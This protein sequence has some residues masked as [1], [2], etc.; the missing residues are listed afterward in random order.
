M[1]KTQIGTAKVENG[2]GTTEYTVPADAHIGENT[3]TGVYQENDT[4]DQA[5]GTG[6]LHIRI[7]TVVSVNNVLAS[8]GE[9]ASFTATVKHHTTQNVEEGQ[10]QFQLAGED[11]GTPVNVVDGLATL[12]YVI[13]SNT[14][15]G[16]VITARF[17]QTDSYAGSDASNGILSIREDSNVTITNLSANRGTTTTITASITDNNG[18]GINTGTAT[19]YI[20]DTQQGTAV[21]VENGAA[22]FNYSIGSEE[23]VGGH[24]IRV[25]YAQNDEYNSATGTGNLVIR[26]PTRLIPVN[27]SATKGGA[28]QVTIQVVDHNNSAITSGT[29]NITVAQ[30]SPVSA[31]LNNNGEA[32]ITYNVPNS[33]T[34]TIN[35][36]G[37]YIENTNYQGSTTTT[38]GIITIRKAVTVTI[39]NIQAV[40]GEEINIIGTITDE[41]NDPVTDGEIIFNIEPAT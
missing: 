14:S 35:F 30:D 40:L 34:G 36:S 38:N 10:V 23:T 7:P 21:T 15:T 25:E 1:V 17:I 9:N 41:D 16:Q 3:L 22:T 31:E 33:A 11:I 37:Q 32:T 8:L 12:Q 19:L 18:D 39:Q 24:V 13:P 20:D 26:T 28:V 6:T 5:T 2:R 4:Y 29:V 27:V